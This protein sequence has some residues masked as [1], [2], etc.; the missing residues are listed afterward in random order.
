[1]TIVWQISTQLYQRS[2]FPLCPVDQILT[3]AIR[4]KKAVS[5][6]TSEL[7]A[8]EARLRAT[9]E[10]LK[11]VASASPQTKSSSGRSS[12]RQRVPL[13]DTFTSSPT[14]AETP[15]SPLTTEFKNTSRP[16]TGRP[17]TGEDRRPVS[18]WKQEAHPSYTTP[19]VPGA[20]PPTP[21]ASE[22]GDI[23]PPPPQKDSYRE[24]V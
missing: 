19:P 8:L 15:T 12:P 21:G 10:R 11:K 3:S 17:Q 7:E 13:G 20:L 2:A 4:R 23:P 16:N 5:Q 18:G 1:L 14:K 22:D 9:G 24:E 6:Q